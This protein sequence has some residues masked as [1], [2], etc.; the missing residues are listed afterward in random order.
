[1]PGFHRVS[2]IHFLYYHATPLCAYMC[3]CQP[4]CSHE[5]IL[6]PESLLV[7]DGYHHCNLQLWGGHIVIRVGPFKWWTVS[8]PNRLNEDLCLCGWVDCLSSF[9]LN[10]SSC[11]PLR[12]RPNVMQGIPAFSRVS[13]IQMS[14]LM[15]QI[16]FFGGKCW[17]HRLCD[18]TDIRW[19]WSHAFK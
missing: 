5:H 13:L 11:L 9:T 17:R 1:M 7:F 15:A 10:Q 4:T 16:L 2:D 12:P 18:C 6:F 14:N 3:V 8:Q 19:V